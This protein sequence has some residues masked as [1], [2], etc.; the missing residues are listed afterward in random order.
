MCRPKFLARLEAIKKRH[1]SKHRGAD[2]F[3]RWAQGVLLVTGLFVLLLL[4]QVELP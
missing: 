1:C 3:P 2:R 4:S